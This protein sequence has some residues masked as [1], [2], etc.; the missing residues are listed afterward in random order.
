MPVVIINDFRDIVP[1]NLSA[2]AKRLPYLWESVIVE[3][4]LNSTYWWKHMF[5]RVNQPNS[6]NGNYS[7][8]ARSSLVIPMQPAALADVFRLGLD[9]EIR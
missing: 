3:S 2:W 7:I 8:D 5:D 4:K 9:N 6:E 1:S